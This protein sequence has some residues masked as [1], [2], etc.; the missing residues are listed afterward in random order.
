MI[1]S[2]QKKKCSNLLNARDQALPGA[3]DEIHWQEADSCQHP[4]SRLADTKTPC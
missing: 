1:G 3:K 4:D 2:R